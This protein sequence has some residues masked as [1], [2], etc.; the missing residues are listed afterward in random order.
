MSSG[1]T[2]PVL[3]VVGGLGALARYGLSGW[4][5]RRLDTTR[6]HGTVVVNLAGTALL[7]A[8]IV[9]WRAEL[10]TDEALIVV[11][12]GFC[13]GFTTFSTWM[14]EMV[15]LAETGRVGRRAAVTDLAGQLA[16]GLLLAAVIL[17][18]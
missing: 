18:A 4:V 8:I 7:T 1:W 3:L 17:V 16:G 6:P 10:V 5:Q 11:G 9:A 12:A 15:R 2:A 13:A 14:L